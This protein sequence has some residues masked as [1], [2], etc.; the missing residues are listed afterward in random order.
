MQASK[1]QKLN[2]LRK[3]KKEDAEGTSPK[4]SDGELFNPYQSKK[5]FK[6]ASA[7]YTTSAVINYQEQ[8]SNHLETVHPNSV[9]ARHSHQYFTL[10]KGRLR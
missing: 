3:K 7:T 5:A 9:S 10:I 6:K 1:Q 2:E 4:A 8:D